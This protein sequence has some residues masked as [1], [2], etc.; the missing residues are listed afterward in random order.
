MDAVTEKTSERVRV[1]LDCDWDDLE[2]ALATVIEAKPSFDN[3]EERVGWG[4][5]FS[6][7]GKPTLFVRRTKTGFSATALASGRRP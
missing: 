6:R 3:A 2:R 7:P 1:I 5:H 4:W